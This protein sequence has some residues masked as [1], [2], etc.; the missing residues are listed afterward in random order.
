MAMWH[1]TGRAQQNLNL[2]NLS[3]PSKGCPI[4]LISSNPLL[5]YLWRG[6][7]VTFAGLSMDCSTVLNSAETYTNLW[8]LS[9]SRQH[10]VPTARPP[11]RSES[12]YTATKAKLPHLRG[13]CTHY[14]IDINALYSV[15]KKYSQNR[16]LLHVSC[17]NI[18]YDTFKMTATF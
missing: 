18:A 2:S 17:R 11:H 5:G 4:L 1:T 15:Q 16:W 12:F 7:C 13:K 10:G 6:R 8:P 14:R 9:F 3:L